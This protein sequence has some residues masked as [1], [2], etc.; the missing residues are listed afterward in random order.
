MDPLLSGI[1]VDPSVCCGK[2]CIGGTRIWVSL[3]LDPLAAVSTTEEI[4]A[5]TRI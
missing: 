3:L 5:T 2:P 4:Q 1:A